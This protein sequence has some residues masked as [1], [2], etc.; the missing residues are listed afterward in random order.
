MT[1]VLGVD[2]GIGGALCAFFCADQEGPEFVADVID[3]PAM[4]DGTKRQVDV[5]ALARWVRKMSPILAAVENVQPMPSIPGVG[6]VRRSMGASTSFRFGMVVGQIRATLQTCGVPMML[7][8]PQVW[9]RY[10]D[11]RG[12]SKE[13]SR[14][15]AR[16]LHP[17]ACHWLERKKDQ[18][19]AE[20]I[21]MAR[22][23]DRKRRGAN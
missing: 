7:V 3:M 11:I 14:M 9:Q 8:H 10:Y 22:W 1:I 15:L 12:A 23:C 21:L 17:E 4:E 20:S 13:D 18:G 19:R 16:D 2:P 5:P 6:G